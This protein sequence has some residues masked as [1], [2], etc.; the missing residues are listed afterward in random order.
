LGDE[1]YGA[2][3]QWLLSQVPAPILMNHWL[4]VEVAGNGA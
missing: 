2:A 1:G 4:L 3:E